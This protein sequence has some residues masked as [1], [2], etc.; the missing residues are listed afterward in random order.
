M[1]RGVAWCA[2]ERQI[3]AKAFVSASENNIVGGDQKLSSFV[4]SLHKYV[5]QYG[6]KDCAD[7]KFGNRVP[8]SIYK[9]LKSEILPD[10]QKF[11][12]AINVVKASIDTGNPSNQDIHCMAIAHH[13]KMSY[14]ADTRY[15]TTGMLSFD[16]AKKWD[17]YLAFLELRK[18]PKF[19][20]SPSAACNNT[21][22]IPKNDC[23]VLS[24]SD[25]SDISGSDEMPVVSNADTTITSIN[26]KKIALTFLKTLVEKLDKKKR[27]W[28]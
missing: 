13:L 22:N 10:V 24:F 20:S 9:F 25:I 5:V 17:N 12:I 3:A 23:P 16:P 6:P 27:N 26:G 14:A 4:H 2:A 21:I 18:N 8:Q 11:S 28:I 19:Y 1:G 7:K 15:M